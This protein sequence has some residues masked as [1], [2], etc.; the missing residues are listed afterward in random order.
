MC[1][2]RDNRQLRLFTGEYEQRRR[3]FQRCQGVTMAD[4][5][6]CSLDP[7]SWSFDN[8]W[9]LNVNLQTAF[10]EAVVN[11]DRFCITFCADFYEAVYKF[12]LRPAVLKITLRLWDNLALTCHGLLQWC[13]IRWSAK[14]SVTTSI[15]AELSIKKFVVHVGT[16][17][18]DKSA[19]K[20][21][22]SSD[23]CIHQQLKVSSYSCRQPHKQPKNPAPLKV[24]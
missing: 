20:L 16:L 6:I 2:A 8:R 18:V 9:Q 21:I 5:Y 12:Y 19:Q 14:F 23:N 3:C 24:E 15:P 10:S 7:E 22:S 4:V 17:L 1:L 13:A 11:G